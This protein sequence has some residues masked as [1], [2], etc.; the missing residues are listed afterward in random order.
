MGASPPTVSV[1][2][3][4]YNCRRY[5]D[6]ALSS[7]LQQTFAD[8]ELIAV[9]DG[10]TDGS[11]EILNR[12]AKQDARLRIISR[13]NT[14]I[15]GA[16]NDAIAAARGEFFARMDGDDISMPQR[17]EKQVQFLREHPNVVLLGS[18]VRLIDPFG[19]P[20]YET[21]HN[22]DHDKIEKEMLDGVGWAVVHPSAMMR[23]AAV[24][25]AGGYKSERVPT[26]DL[27]LFLRMTEIGKAANLPDILLQ[28]RQHHAS[29]N[30]TRVEEQNRNKRAILTEAYARRGLTLP[31]GWTPPKRDIL[32]LEKE[33]SMWGWLALKHGSRRAARHHAMSLL[34]L[35]PFSVG[36]WRL[37]FC[38][39][40]GY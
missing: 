35:A 12:Y 20:L 18:R 7:I 22:L 10:S 40:R 39:L 9:D 19:I 26:E 8:F 27:D 6:E 3:P 15:A 2:L 30:H 25:T 16:L 4:A 21:T 24:R 13:P 11:L 17:F 36:S 31:S 38:A 34:R 5:L 14:G 32:P 37:L 33:L 1:L 29:A 28:Y 23:A